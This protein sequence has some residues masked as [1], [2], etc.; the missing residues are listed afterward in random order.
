MGEYVP[1]L[2]PGLVAARRLQAA[3]GHAA[4]GRLVHARRQRAALAEVVAPGRLQPPRGAR[5]AHRRLRGRRPRPPRRAP[6]LLRRDGRALPRPDARALPAHRVRHRR[7]G[8]RV[9]DHV[10]RAGLRLPGR[11]R[12]PRRG[13]ARHRAA[14]RTRSR[15]AICIHEE[16]DA[17]L[18]KHVDAAGRRRGA[19]LAPARRLLPRDG[20]QLRVPRLLAL[21]PGRQH[22]VRGA[23]DRD[24]GHHPLRPGRAAALRHARRRA[25]LRAVPPAL[26][27]RPAGPRRRR[28][29]QHGGSRRSPRRCPSGPD[30][31]H[32][33]ALVQRDTPLRT[34]ARGPPGLRLE[35]PAGLEGRQPARPQRARHPGRLQARARRRL[36]GHARPGLARAAARGGDRATR[37]GSRRTHEDERWPCGEFVVQSARATSACRPGRRR[38]DR[39]R[40]PMS[41]C[42]TCSASTM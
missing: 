6:A 16:D 37:C 15:N 40:T 33:L 8:P 42:G 20:G 29:G 30:N 27:R 9:H 31:P 22:R 4:R 12:L 13:P 17:I 39:S 3:R 7:V 5:A 21:L 35:H 38:I 32:G 19:P 2:V 11:D 28:G 26:P 1:R 23:G 25:H 36:P 18:W 14:S 10:A 41:C 24:H 34:E